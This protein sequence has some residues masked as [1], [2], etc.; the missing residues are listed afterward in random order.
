MFEVFFSNFSALTFLH[1]GVSYELHRG[2][3]K[4]KREDLF[5][6]GP[7]NTTLISNAK[8][9]PSGGNLYTSSLNAFW[10]GSGYFNCVFH[11]NKYNSN[12]EN[13]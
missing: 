4:Q 1:R 8:L 7:S 3:S 11:Y 5:H 6:N 12:N 9:F 13:I 10:G 2:G